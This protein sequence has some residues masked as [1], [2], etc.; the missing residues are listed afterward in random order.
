M[1]MPTREQLA[2]VIFDAAWPLCAGQLHSETTSAASRSVTYA[3][4]DAVLA[5]LN[6]PSGAANRSQ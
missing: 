3:M 1:N 5:R 2:E 6:A 4:A